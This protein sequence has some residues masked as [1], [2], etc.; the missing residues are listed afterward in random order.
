MP[1]ML[2]KNPDLAVGL[3]LPFGPGQSDFALN[4]TT[5]DQAKTNLM[6]L[7][8]TQKGERFMQPDFG[9][10]LR[11]LIF[12]PN[13]DRIEGRIKEEIVDSVNYWLP[14]IA[15]TKVDAVRHSKNIDEYSVDVNITFSLKADKFSEAAI[16]FAFNSD[17]SVEVN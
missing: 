14:Y 7:L 13:T 15:L 8:L 3:K 12:E 9:T 10:G 11:R 17:S 6:N 1:S 5:I 4:Y 16:T 2:D